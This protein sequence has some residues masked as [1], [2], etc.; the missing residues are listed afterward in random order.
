MATFGSM[1]WS[2]CMTRID[3]QPAVLLT[4]A[5]PVVGMDLS[6]ALEQAGYHVIGPVDT[7]E[8]AL[9]HLEDAKPTVAVID[10]QLK[11]G[12]CTALARELR[13]RG[14]PFLIHSACRQDQRLA[15][16][17]QGIPW[18][19]K[20]AQPEDVVVLCDELSLAGHEMAGPSNS[21]FHSD[22]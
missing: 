19:S 8:H 5:D 21:P 20:P 17:F 2:V 13:W 11:D 4:E 14:L 16:D 18:L 3:E 22:A 10:V 12:R 1:S 9:R 6:D 7:V 15:G